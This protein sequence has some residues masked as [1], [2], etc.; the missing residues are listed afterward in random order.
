MARADSTIDDLWGGALPFI[1]GFELWCSFVIDA[2]VAGVGVLGV[3]LMILVALTL[4][5]GLGFM[6]YRWRIRQEMRDE[7]KSILKQY[8][9]LAGGDE[10][11]E[12]APVSAP[13][14]DE[15]V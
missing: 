12:K 10:D 15:D 9:P 8:M 11:P 2:C 4:V 1:I 5:G 13:R 14:S 3:A 7:V 6:L